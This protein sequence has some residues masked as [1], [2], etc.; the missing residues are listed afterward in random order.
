MKNTSSILIEIIRSY[1]SSSA[2]APSVLTAEYIELCTRYGLGPILAELYLESETDIQSDVRDKL[3]SIKI[4]AQYYSALYHSAISEIADL[5]SESD[6]NIILLKGMHT[7]E[8][9]YEQNYLRLMG[10]IDL[11]VKEE[12]VDRVVQILSSIGYQQ[13]GYLPDDFFLTH[14]H[15]KPFH[16]KG[17][18]IW[19]ELHTCL[20]SKVSQ[21]GKRKLF[22]PQSIFTNLVSIDSYGN[23][24]YGLNAELNLHYSITHWVREF[25]ISNSLIQIVDI[26]LIIEKN[27][28]NWD[29]FVDA[30]ESRSH[31]TEIKIVLKLL[32]R[33]NLIQLSQEVRRKIFQKR[34]S[35][36]LVGRWIMSGI[37]NSY[38]KQNK[39]IIEIIGQANCSSVWDG[40][41]RDK[42][43]FSNHFHAIS[44]VIFAEIPGS[45]SKWHSLVVR[46][47]R[48]YLRISGNR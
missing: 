47:K 7:S 3:Q 17:K 6:I 37:I 40:Y 26:I 22:Q 43:S 34:D 23:H 28:I 8:V 10:D 19:V 48:L 21:H 41:L 30:I 15:L 32:L 1:I 38:L 45:T 4:T 9:Y 24:V 27:S 42:H 31:A 35:A 18:D 12:H 11:L 2:P 44:S 33:C 16:Q 29:E 25:K 5:L 39:F 13:E 46:L 36:G 14:Q 20:F